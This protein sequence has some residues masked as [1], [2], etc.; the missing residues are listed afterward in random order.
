MVPTPCHAGGRVKM[1]Q[2]HDLEL[3]SEANARLMP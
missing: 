2:W 3:T 1:R